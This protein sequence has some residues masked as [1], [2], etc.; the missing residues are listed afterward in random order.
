MG[1]ISMDLGPAVT[2]LMSALNLR[3]GLWV[4]HPKNSFRG[5]YRFP[6][7]FFLYELLGRSRANA[8]ARNLLLSDG[9][10]FENFGLYELI[11]RHVRYI[12]V[13]DCG[14]D[15]EVAFDDLANVLR[16]VREDF[17]VEIELDISALRPG[18]NGLAKQHAVV[19]TIH[20]NWITGMDKGTII[21]FKPTLTGDE[22]PDIL[23]YRTRNRAFPHESTGDQFYDEPQWE[24]YRR[25]GEHAA[26]SALG[27]FDQPGS[28][29][30][31]Q[32]DKLFRDARAHWPPSPPRHQETFLEM[33]Q[34]FV[35]LQIDL[36]ANGPP[37]LRAEIFSEITELSGKPSKLPDADEE[38]AIFA[39]LLRVT[40]LMEDVWVSHDLD[41]YW[42]HPLNEGWMAYFNRWASTASFRRWWPVLAPIYSLRFREF[43][44]ERFHVGVKDESAR[45]GS[46]RP[47]K[48][49]QLNLSALKESDLA[50]F[51]DSHTGRC[52]QQTYPRFSLPLPE[53]TTFFKY[54]LDLLGYDGELS[55]K[56][57]PVG[58]VIVREEQTSND[59]W[60]WWQSTE[61]FV[62]RSM[63][64]GGILARLLDAL[65]KQYE[66]RNFVR[67]E[68]TFAPQ[69]TGQKEP[70]SK[71]KV[72]S[73]AE[74]QQRVQDIEF[75]KSRGFQY[76]EFEDPNTGRIVLA[77]SLDGNNKN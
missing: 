71:P 34:R 67:L 46:E 27:F 63:H 76:V 42:S 48:S 17:G 2:F 26:R 20:Y 41:Q 54:E 6:G 14:A 28:K 21:F 35:S 49:G 10:H 13:S 16:R 7:R 57:L 11:R 51:M 74:R 32:V 55:G 3:L 77:L 70:P 53:N 29:A 12:I 36:L 59:H 22:P 8:R 43:A 64:G 31:K 39:F 50:Q 65:V 40:Q 69:A 61:F 56:N 30:G 24:S 37:H 60:A 66:G 68:V 62:P 1:R 9:N 23:Q 73:Q 72:L 15:P 4:P 47:I 25:L 38:M 45:P 19:G 75:Y 33:T 52:F 58:L 18:D 44:K 5:Y